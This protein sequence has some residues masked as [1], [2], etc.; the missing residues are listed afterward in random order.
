MTKFASKTDY[1]NLKSVRDAYP[2]A[3]KIV[4]VDGGWLVFETTTDYNTWV[5]QR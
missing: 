5:N 4:R 1:T 2:G 3:T